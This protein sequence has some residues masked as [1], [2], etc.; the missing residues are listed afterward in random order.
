VA[1]EHELL[2]E[3]VV[4]AAKSPLCEQIGRLQVEVDF[5]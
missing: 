5:L 4:E 3:D 1:G 2:T